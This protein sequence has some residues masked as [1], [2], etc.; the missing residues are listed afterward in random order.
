MSPKKVLITGVYGL[1]GSTTYLSLRSQPDQ[2]ELYGLD[3][4]RQLSERAP[5]DRVVD[6]P[7]DRFYQADLT[8]FDAIRQ[9]VSGKAVVVHLAAD[10]QGRNWESLLNNNL[11]GAYHVFEACK[12][13]GVSRIVFASTYLVSQGYAEEEPYTSIVRGKFD[14]VPSSYTR[15]TTDHAARPRDLY[16][17]SKLFN[18]SLAHVY[19]SDSLS[20]LGIRIGGVRNQPDGRGDV[21][22]SLRDLVQLITCCINAPAALRHDVFYAMSHNRWAWVD[23]ENARQKVGYAPQ[24]SAEDYE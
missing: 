4:H 18:E 15:L 9:A 20:C 22:V 2:Y 16:A 3:L 13:T 1:I 23:I 19:Q 10:P 5:Q 12:Q 24:D 21:W 6:L 8:D 11:K 17:A 7:E 14:A